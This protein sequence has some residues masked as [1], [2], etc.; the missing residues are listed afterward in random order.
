MATTQPGVGITLNLKRNW[1]L[2]WLPLHQ[3]LRFQFQQLP[4]YV[5]VVVLLAAVVAV[6]A[7]KLAADRS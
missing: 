5:D 3:R 6:L 7:V 4:P 1:Q 2:F